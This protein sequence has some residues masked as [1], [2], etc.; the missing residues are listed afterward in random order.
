MNPWQSDVRAF[1]EKFG[2]PVGKQINLND[3]ELRATLILEEACE[4]IAAMGL[5]VDAELYRPSPGG[6]VRLLAF[7]EGA[8]Q[9][10]VTFVADGLADLIYVAI[11]AAVSFG[12]DLDPIFAEVHRTN[13]LKVGGATREDGKILKPAG[14]EPP[15]ILEALLKQAAHP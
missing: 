1:H 10:D 3:T 9:A 6:D 2:V 11:G 12:I 14:W 8:E 4:T 13:M 15:R 5:A 7:S